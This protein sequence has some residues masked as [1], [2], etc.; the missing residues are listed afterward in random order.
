[1][2]GSQRAKSQKLN[3]WDRSTMR[4]GTPTVVYSRAAGDFTQATDKPEVPLDVRE[5]LVPNRKGASF[6]SA[7][8]LQPGTG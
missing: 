2:A 5:P 8:F 1:M 3:R 7:Q 4:Y 6:H